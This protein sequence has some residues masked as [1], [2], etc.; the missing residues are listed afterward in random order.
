MGGATIGPGRTGAGMDGNDR[1]ALARDKGWITAVLAVIWIGIVLYALNVYIL[2]WGAA[3]GSDAAAILLVAAPPVLLVSGTVI[4]A[5]GR[6]VV[7]TWIF[8][9]L[10]VLVACAMGVFLVLGH[11]N[12]ARNCYE[13]DGHYCAQR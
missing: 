12:A 5:I 8:A 11:E 2:A 9:G 3:L 4:A 13:P 1:V 6:R 10:I 7:Q